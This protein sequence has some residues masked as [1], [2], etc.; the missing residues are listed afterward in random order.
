MVALVAA[1][2]VDSVFPGKGTR[3]RRRLCDGRVVLR[4]WDTSDDAVTLTY[5]NTGGELRACSLRVIP[6]QATVSGHWAPAPSCCRG[7][8]CCQPRSAST[9]SCARCDGPRLAAV[10]AVVAVML[11]AWASLALLVHLVIAEQWEGAV[12]LVVL[13]VLVNLLECVPGMR[14]PALQQQSAC[15]TVLGVWCRALSLGAGNLWWLVAATRADKVG[16]RDVPAISRRAPFDSSARSVASV[17]SVMLAWPT[18]AVSAFVLCDDA[19]STADRAAAVA[20]VI[21]CGAAMMLGSWLN[22]AFPLAR[23][24]NVG[25]RTHRADCK[26]AFSATAHAM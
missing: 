5:P 13:V 3:F 6:R 25:K 8:V 20:G 7:R 24:T 14:G 9:A 23:T 18:A 19:S 21:V 11:V 17:R 22:Y 16:L 12:A 4:G 1:D 15:G 10:A 26:L 2:G